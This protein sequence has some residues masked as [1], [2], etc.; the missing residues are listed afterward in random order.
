MLSSLDQI[1][2]VSLIAAQLLIGL[3]LIFKAELSHLFIFI[4]KSTMAVYEQDF[5]FFNQGLL[6][7]YLVQVSLRHGDAQ[8][9]LLY[10]LHY[11]S[12][13]LVGVEKHVVGKQTDLVVCF[14]TAKN[15]GV[16]KHDVCFYI[17]GQLPRFQIRQRFL[18]HK[19]LDC[20]G[21]VRVTPT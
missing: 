10:T 9:R 16:L 20:L 7:L 1:T 11:I 13:S 3:L 15:I 18:S 12:E 5:W 6:E 14:L 19:V 8:I 17:F 21:F 2:Y 4:G